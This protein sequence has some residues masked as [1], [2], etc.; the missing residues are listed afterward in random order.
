SST[1]DVT[2]KRLYTYCFIFM[3]VIV[4]VKANNSRSHFETKSRQTDIEAHECDVIIAGGSTASLG[5]AVAAARA[6]RVNGNKVCLTEPTDW[7]GGQLT[8]SAVSAIDFGKFNRYWWFQSTTFQ[9]IMDSLGTGNP[10]RCWVSTKCYLPMD[11]INGW[12][13][14]TISSFTNLR[15]FYNTVIKSSRHNGTLLYAVYAIQRTQKEGVQQWSSLLSTTITDWYSYN[16]S[17]MFT[18]QLLEFSRADGKPPVVIDAT[19]FGDILAVSGAGFR[20]GV[21]TPV[22]ESNTTDEKCG[23]RFT[24]PFYIKVDQ[25]TSGPENVSSVGQGTYSLDG[26]SWGVVWSYRRSKGVSAGNFNEAYIGEISN[27]NWSKGNDFWDKYILVSVASA[28]AEV[29]NWSGGVNVNALQQAESRSYGWYHFYKNQA[30][31]F[32]RSFL[33]LG[34]SSIVGTETCLAK[35]PYIRDTR[36]SIGLDMFILR[37]SDMDSPVTKWPDTSSYDPTI[38]KPLKS[39]QYSTRFADS[40]AIGDYVAD[41]HGLADCTWPDYINNYHTIPFHIPF[42]SLTNRQFGNLLVAGKTMAQTFMANAATRTHPTEFVT[43]EAAGTAAILMLKNEYSSR[44]MY[45]H[46]GDL[47]TELKRFMPI[48]WDEPRQDSAVG[49]I[50][51]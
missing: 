5:A 42:R 7:L 28:T 32:L 40:I 23:Q 27:E 30:P 41:V 12:I 37:K 3:W 24:I 13:N 47:Q 33:K 4:H 14:K 51:G 9:S 26:K 15:V 43:G 11:L 46:V 44:E 38:T 22:E 35:V 39:T 2:M 36:R 25:N 20:Q 6:G 49:N 34:C 16:E 10:G 31:D 19:E 17:T 29:D 50:F 21:E 48:F 45:N 18:K 8:S 1:C